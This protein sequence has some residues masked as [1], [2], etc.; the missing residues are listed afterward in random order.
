[1]KQSAARRTFHVSR[2]EAGM[3]LMSFLKTKLDSSYSAK[4][5]K[6][7]IDRR[8]CMVN[9]KSESFSSY[10]V[11]FRDRIE[12]NEGSMLKFSKCE[13]VHLRILFEDEDLLIISKAAGITSANGEI[14]N[15]LPVKYPYLEIVH[16]LDRHTSGAL[17]LVKNARAKREMERLFKEREIHKEYLAIV[18]GTPKEKEGRVENYMGKVSSWEGQ[19]LWGAVSQ[20]GKYALTEYTMLASGNGLSLIQAIPQTGRT[21]Q[22]RSHFASIGIPILGDY[23]YAKSFHSSREVTRQMLHANS[24]KFTFFGKEISVTAPLTREMRELIDEVFS[25]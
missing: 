23:Q 22:I 8:A 21:H 7:A 4:M 17:V 18:D 5:I 13:I 1:M 11:N 6:R 16:R 10:K 12:F 20:N 15:H 14:K 19:S 9:G 2:E 3:R 24:L 25:C